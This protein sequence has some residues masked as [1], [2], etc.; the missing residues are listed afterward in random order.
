[1]AGLSHRKSDE[2]HD[3]PQVSNSWLRSVSRNV[4]FLDNIKSRYID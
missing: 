3:V 4:Y 2:I 1:M